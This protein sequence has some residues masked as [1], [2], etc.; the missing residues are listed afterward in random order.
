MSRSKIELIERSQMPTAGVTRTPRLT[1]E[2]AMPSITVNG[3]EI[4]HEL[5]G[6]GP[7]LL[8]ISGATGDAG[9]FER[10]ADLLADELAVVTYDRRGHSRSPRPEG[11]DT[12]SPNEQAD[13]A[14]AL[15]T[16]LELGPAA[17]F[18]NSYGAIF[19]LNLVIRHPEVVRGAILHEPPLISVL[20][21][22]E[23][24][25]AAVGGAVEKGMA[26]GGPPAAVESFIRFAAG[27]ANWERLEPD[28]RERMQGNGETL[29]DIEMGKFEDYRPDD[30]TLGAVSVPVEVLVSEESAPFFTEAAGWLAERLGVE[31]VRTPGTH[32]P[33][34]DRPEELV[35]TIRSFLRKLEAKAAL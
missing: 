19:A 4:Y 17:V 22:P 8:F 15:L 2:D 32:T 24:T 5:K 18:G 35:N 29:F 23:E 25:Q 20:E 16:A 31:I 26:S 30:A 28:L 21:R 14:A 12:T 7:S 27:D 6:S 9:H 11:W 1:K 34:W 3:T 13:D 33:Q 10:V